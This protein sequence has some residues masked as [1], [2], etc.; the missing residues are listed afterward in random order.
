MAFDRTLMFKELDIET[1]ST[2][3]RS[4]PTCLRNSSPR[5]DVRE[6]FGKPHYLPTYTVLEILDQ[7]KMIG[8]TG[9]VNLSHFNEPLQDERLA[10]FGRYAKDLLVF[11]TVMFHTN[12]DLLTQRRAD[13]L[14]GSFD[15]ATV[16][17]YDDDSQENRDRLQNMMPN[18]RLIWTGGEHIV[19]HFSPSASLREWVEMSRPQPCRRGAQRRAIIDYRGN[20]LLCCEDIGAWPSFGNISDTSLYDLWFSNKH[21][22]VLAT[23][24]EPGGRERYAYCR[25]CP[26][27]CEEN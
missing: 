11:E 4:C 3:N 20:L 24:N 19:T 17:L 13:S 21:M 18:T 23:L 10:L 16:A 8:F 22:T 27:P 6:R 15:C 25:S 7:A 2:C 14:D 26:R 12:G 5:A 9:T 1:V